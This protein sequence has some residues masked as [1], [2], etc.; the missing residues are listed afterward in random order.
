MGPPK[1]DAIERKRNHGVEFRQPGFEELK[2]DGQWKPFLG[3]TEQLHADS[4]GSVLY[5]GFGVKFH[6]NKEL[7]SFLKKCEI[8]RLVGPG[9]NP[10]A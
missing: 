3:S 10:L 8:H 9:P 5:A 6:V 1:Q 4:G 2:Q 7:C